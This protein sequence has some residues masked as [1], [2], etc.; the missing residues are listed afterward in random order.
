VPTS[1]TGHIYNLVCKA[2]LYGVDGDCIDDASEAA[3]PSITT[4]TAFEA[5]MH[6]STD[7]AKLI[8]WRKKGTDWQAA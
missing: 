7:E 5:T 6:N 1:G 2:I 3:S 4:V 8:A